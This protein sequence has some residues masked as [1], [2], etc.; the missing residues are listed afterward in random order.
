MDQ[1]QVRMRDVMAQKNQA[2]SQVD[3]MVSAKQEMEAAL[4][5]KV[6]YSIDYC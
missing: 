2:M 5:Q 1:L 3:E 4:F 6:R